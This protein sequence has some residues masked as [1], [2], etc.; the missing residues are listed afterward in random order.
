MNNILND[1]VLGNKKPADA[2][3][4]AQK[5]MQAILDKPPV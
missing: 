3:A 5:A 2:A 4:E 1:M